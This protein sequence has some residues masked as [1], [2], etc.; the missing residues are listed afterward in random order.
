M[1]IEKIKKLYIENEKIYF[2]SIELTQNCNFRCKHCYCTDKMQPNLPLKSYQLILDKLYDYGCLFLNFTGGEILTNK[3]FYEIYKYAKN[4][5][6]IIDLLSN[7]SLINDKTIALFKELPPHTIAI[8]IYGTNEFEYY[9]FTGVKNSY[10]LVMSNLKKLKE[11]NIHFVLRTVATKTNFQ[12]LYNGKFNRI[13]ESF[14]VSFKYDPIVFPMISGDIS[15]LSQC[16]TTEEIVCLESNSKVISDA[17]SKQM[18][19]KKYVWTCRAGINSIAI[20]YRGIAYVCGLYRK[21]GISL[22]YNSIEEVH[23]HLK[24]IHKNHVNIVKNSKCSKCPNRIICKWC[25]AYSL[26]YN[27]NDE[28]PINFFCELGNE[29]RRKFG[30]K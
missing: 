24:C 17:W 16:L 21:N 18:S 7:I 13:A 11:N 9:N 23:E 29:R 22:L 6:F 14:D 5:G 25:P 12:S 30:K 8:T 28:Q 4:K 27:G 19:E 10:N 2:A 20:D 3:D 1:N 15:T 26:I